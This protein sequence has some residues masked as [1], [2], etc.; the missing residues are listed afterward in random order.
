[1]IRHHREELDI[2]RGAEKAHRRG[3]RR[4][5]RYFKNARSVLQST[6]RGT[7]GFTLIEMAFACEVIMLLSLI[8]FNET[9]RVKE[10]ALVSACLQYQAIV[11]R[12][13]WGEYALDGDFPADL[14]PMLAKLPACSAGNDF[15]YKGGLAAGLDSDYYLRCG[16]NHS[17]V[18]VLF[19]DS[20]SYLPPKVIYNL[21][22]ARGAIP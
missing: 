8:T 20:G 11:Q 7:A 5:V 1:M 17:Y 16:H 18:G 10:H 4:I 13:L 3:V 21:A 14:A 6:H 9:R 12:S 22:S 15:D 2:T 19:V